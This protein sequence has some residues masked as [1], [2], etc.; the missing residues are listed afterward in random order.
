MRAD[1]IVVFSKAEELVPGEVAEQGRRL[2]MDLEPVRK[3][4]QMLK[5]V[6][7]QICRGGGF[8]GC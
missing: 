2:W 6:K 7:M 5:H 3:D 1:P 4:F 8:C